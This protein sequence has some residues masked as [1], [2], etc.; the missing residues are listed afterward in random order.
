[1]KEERNPHP[2]RPWSWWGTI[3]ASEK[4]ATAGLRK[5]K[6]KD[7]YTDYPYHCPQ[8]PQPETLLLGV[9]AETQVSEVSSGK[10]LGLAAWRQ[11]ER[12]GSSASW[13][14]EWS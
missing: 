3:K 11:P 13:A 10:G 2:G 14:R 4:R 12:L 8:A 7:T 5:A 9:G 6:Q 1:M